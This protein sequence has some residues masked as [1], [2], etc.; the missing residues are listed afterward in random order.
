M[1]QTFEH[2]VY[3]GI[4]IHDGNG[5]GKNADVFCRLCA[6]IYQISER[7]GK[8]DENSRRAYGKNRREFHGALHDIADM[9]VSVDGFV[10]RIK[11]GKLRDY[12]ACKG[13]ADGGGEENERQHH[14]V[15]RAVGGKSRRG[16]GSGFFQSYR[17]ENML[18]RHKPR[19]QI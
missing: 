16:V 3:C 15:Y 11:L 17:Y 14:A 18:C 4:C 1:P 13:N 10:F 2:T 8:A 19:A 7:L 5:G 9:S 6:R 12:Q